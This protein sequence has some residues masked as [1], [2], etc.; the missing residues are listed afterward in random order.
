MRKSQKVAKDLQRRRMR[1]GRLLLKGVAQAEVARRVGV[2]R[3]TVS[4]W[5]R[6]LQKDG[7]DGLMAG[8]R[9]RPSRLSEEH[10]A[11]LLKALLNGALAEG[12]PT[13]L[14]TLS[15]V[16]MLIERQSGHRYSE[17]QVWRILTGLG[18]SS[19]RPSSRAL[20]RNE[21]AIARW[22]R[23]RWPALK[24]TLRDKDESSSSSTSRD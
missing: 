11:Q 5:N 18:F 22:K 1:A 7:L 3:T 23:D 24:K 8:V 20:E 19:Q 13:E 10:R 14:W 12:F 21:S 9:G 16:G 6:D 17:S 2:T 4:V 15:R